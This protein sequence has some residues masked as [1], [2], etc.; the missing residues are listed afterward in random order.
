MCPSSSLRRTQEQRLIAGELRVWGTCV[1]ECSQV[2]VKRELGVWGTEGEARPPFPRG[3]PGE[4]A[5][6]VWEAGKAPQDFSIPLTESLKSRLPADR[7]GRPWV[8]AR[9]VY[10]CQAL[11]VNVCLGAFTE[12]VSVYLLFEN[13]IFASVYR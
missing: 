1:W 11:A 10:L 12:F 6:Q 8:G 7:V 13:C 9:E 5:L 4:G 2:C 3:P